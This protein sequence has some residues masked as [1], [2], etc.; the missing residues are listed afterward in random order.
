[1]RLRL[2]E[3]TLLAQE[4]VDVHLEDLHHLFDAFEPE[5]ELRSAAA[6]NEEVWND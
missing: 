5:I 1:M 6:A 2:E 3:V 4:L